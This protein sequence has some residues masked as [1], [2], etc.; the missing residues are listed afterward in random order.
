MIESPPGVNLPELFEEG[1]I[2][3]SSSNTGKDVMV[4]KVPII[5]LLELQP[6]TVEEK[7]AIPQPTPGGETLVI[8]EIRKYSRMKDLDIDLD[9]RMSE[10]IMKLGPKDTLSIMV[11]V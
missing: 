1:I 7:V 10:A 4:E 9:P 8:Q 2:D 11:D 6:K 5:D 3:D